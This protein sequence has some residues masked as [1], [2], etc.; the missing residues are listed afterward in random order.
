MM[1]SIFTITMFL[2]TFLHDAK[3][4]SG[5]WYID[6]TLSHMSKE[7]KQR[8]ERE[9]KLACKNIQGTFQEFQVCKVQCMVRKGNYVKLEYVKLKDGLPCGRYGEVCQQGICYGPCDVQ[10]FEKVR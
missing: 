9:Y 4:I 2:A 3:S 1:M 8:L 5:N 7:C 10:F 6:K